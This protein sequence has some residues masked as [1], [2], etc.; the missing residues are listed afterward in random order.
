M[1]LCYDMM[2]A[3]RKINHFLCYIVKKLKKKVFDILIK[4][5]INNQYV[6]KHY[7][8]SFVY[9]EFEAICA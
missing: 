4:Q 8:N 6:N 3:E 5:Y 1:T 7:I 9:D 2:I